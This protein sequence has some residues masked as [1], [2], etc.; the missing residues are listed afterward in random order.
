MADRGGGEA[1]GRV[2]TAGGRIQHHKAVATP[3]GTV[4]GS[5]CASCGG[6]QVG[7]RVSAG[8]DGLLQLGHRWRGLLAGRRQVG[9]GV[10]HI[11]AP[12]GVTAQVQD[13]T[14]GQLQAHGARHTGVDLVA[15]EQAITFNEDAASTF[16]RNYENLTNNAFDGGNNTA[17]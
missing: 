15:R 1:D 8:G 17:H 2:Y 4:T 5:V 10:R 13:A 12:L 14:V 6:F 7:G 9:G 11:G 16:R 3:G